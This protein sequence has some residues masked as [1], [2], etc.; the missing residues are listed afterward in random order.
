MAHTIHRPKQEPPKLGGMLTNCPKRRR[1]PFYPLSHWSW[2]K[3]IHQCEL[4]QGRLILSQCNHHTSSVAFIFFERTPYSRL[5]SIPPDTDPSPGI[6]TLY[7]RNHSPRLQA[8]FPVG[9]IAGARTHLQK[10]AVRL[11]P[12]RAESC[13]RGQ[14]QIVL[15][16]QL[17]HSE[18]LANRPG[19]GNYHSERWLDF[20]QVSILILPTLRLQ[21]KPRG[22]SAGHQSSP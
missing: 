2:T 15:P 9:S 21:G 7:L 16:R 20:S 11:A 3:Y 18:L 22:C 8:V 5:D 4:A 13:E 17:L 1:P 10:I 19:I 6:R 12:V 14:H